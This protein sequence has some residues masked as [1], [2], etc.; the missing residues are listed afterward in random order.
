MIKG[1]LAVHQI[2]FIHVDSYWKSTFDAPIQSTKELMFFS[3]NT[4]IKGKV[5]LYVR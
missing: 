4:Y 3:M 5:S 2:Y 1:H